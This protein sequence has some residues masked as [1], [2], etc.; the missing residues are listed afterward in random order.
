MSNS[1]YVGKH[2]VPQPDCLITCNQ[3]KYMGDHSHISMELDEVSPYCFCTMSEDA[4]L[5][6]GSRILSVEYLFPV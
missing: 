4:S 2:F 1:D 5:F 3:V 6:H